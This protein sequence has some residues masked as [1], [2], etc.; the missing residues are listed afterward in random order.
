MNELERKIIDALKRR[1]TFSLTRLVKILTVVGDNNSI[2]IHYITF[3]N[4]DGKI[5]IP[6][7]TEDY[8]KIMNATN[9]QPDIDRY[10]AS[11][12]SSMQRMMRNIMRM[13]EIPFVTPT[14]PETEEE[15]EFEVIPR[16]NELLIVGRAEKEPEVSIESILNIGGRRIELPPGNWRIVEK[17]LNNGVLTIKLEKI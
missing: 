2:V 7:G 9:I 11:M 8:Y 5:V 10:I 15:N 12:F 6:K 14:L 13:M 1:D 16:G 3:D 4:K 17:K